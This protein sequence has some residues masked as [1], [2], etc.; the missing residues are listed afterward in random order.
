MRR[1]FSR[2]RVGFVAAAVCCSAAPASAAVTYIYTGTA[3][4]SFAG[5]NV[6]GE[7]T[8][9]NKVRVTFT[10][11]SLLTN[12]NFLAN[13]T[14]LDWTVTDGRQ[15]LTKSQF[16]SEF[17]SGDGATFGLQTDASGSVTEWVLQ[18][19]RVPRSPVGSV[20]FGQITTNSLNPLLV[21][22]EGAAIY[23]CALVTSGSCNSS[24]NESFE[25]AI[26]RSGWQISEV[27]EVPIPAAL[28]LF[29]SAVVA[30][31]IISR[32]RRRAQQ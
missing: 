27:N 9:A 1:L 19:S 28:P 22:N 21:G 14:P 5:F 12:F 7:Y 18:V 24:F 32:R 13:I 11:P 25:A 8:A 23:A 20:S 16:E 29:A 10:V 17:L 3:A 6:P 4:T 15:T 26:N 2:V 31:G 30:G